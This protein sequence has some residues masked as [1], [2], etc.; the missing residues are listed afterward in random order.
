MQIS[1]DKQYTT[2]NGHKVRLYA[3]DGGGEYP[4]HAAVF[5]DGMWKSNT[6]TV[7]GCYYMDGTIDNLD[8]IEI[9]PLQDKD[10]VYAW[11]NGYTH[12][13]ISGFYDKIN[14]RLFDIDGLRGGIAYSNYELIEN[15]PQWMIEAQKT[16][17]D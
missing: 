2:R 7:K 11:D 9:K 4:I 13:R 8:L 17:K 3:V 6:W 1:L 15:P 16:L 10:P 14:K 12:L 5:I